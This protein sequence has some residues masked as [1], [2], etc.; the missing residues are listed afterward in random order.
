MKR[1]A[2]KG[3]KASGALRSKT[4]KP[5]RRTA[6]TVGR[7]SRASGEQ[8]PT[9]EL[10]E[11]RRLL[12]GAFE[13][14]TATADV[15]KVISRSTFDLQTV[16]DTLVTSAGRLCQAENVQIFLR[17]DEVYRLAAHNDFSPEYQEYVRQHPIAPG[18]GTLVARTALEVA[19]IHIPDALADPEY[20]WHEG[21][22]LGGFRTMLGIPLLREGTC[23]GVM[24]LTRT[25][26]QPFSGAQIALVTTF[27]DQA[28]IAIENTR[29]LNEL[30]EI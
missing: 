6:A 22:R 12:A 14:Q 5:K 29:L 2:T 3:G 17:D 9:S 30:R 7:R 23:V 11:A 8:Q 1:R 28:V 24:A 25:T 21:R 18:R 15:L 10:A 20:T 13:Q 16:L 4:A 19:P 26:P 27:A